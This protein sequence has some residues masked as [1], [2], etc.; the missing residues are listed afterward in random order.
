MAVLT[1]QWYIIV[2][3][4]FPYTVTLTKEHVSHLYCLSLIAT[5]MLPQLTKDGARTGWL[6]PSTCEGL[7]ALVD[8]RVRCLMLFIVKTTEEICAQVLYRK[9]WRHVPEWVCPIHTRVTA[10]NTL[11]LGYNRVSRSSLVT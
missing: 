10:R 9:N 4:T 7:A 2:R 11:Y 5:T 3:V 8:T 1:V 6:S